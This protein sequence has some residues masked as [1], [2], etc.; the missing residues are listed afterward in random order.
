MNQ[1]WLKPALLGIDRPQVIAVG[2]ALDALLQ[3]VADADEPALAYSRQV[4]VLAACDRAAVRTAAAVSVPPPVADD[5]LQLAADHPWGALLATVFQPGQFS[6][7]GKRL[8]LQACAQLA[9]HGRHLPVA[10]LPQALEAGARL[11]VL[12]EALRAVLGVRGYWLAA[13]NPEW[14]YAS[15]PL[16][17]QASAEEVEQVW[18][19]G[20]SEARLAVFQQQRLEDAAAAR[21]R[22]QDSLKELPARERA[23]FVAALQP[24]LGADDAPLL[25]ALLKDRSREVRAL[26]GPMLARLPDSAHAAYL[27]A[28]MAALLQQ[29]RSGL[30]RRLAWTLEAPATLDPGWAEAAIDGKRPNGEVLGERAWWLYQLAR[31]LPLAWWCRTLEKPAAEVVAW[32]RASDW[33]QALLRAWLERVDASEP[34]WVEALVA[35]KETHARKSELLALLPAAQRERYWPAK[36]QDLIA[37]GLLDDVL[38]STGAAQSLSAAYSQALAPSVGAL[39]GDERLRYDYLLRDRLLELLAVLHPSTLAGVQIAE[40]PATATDAML[41]C[42]QQA[43]ALLALRQALYSPF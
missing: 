32:A 27:Q 36:L 4:G 21:T 15:A 30:L 42:A 41:H 12:R 10:V 20:S 38:D 31:Q 28:Q 35:L 22:L 29:S 5:P 18:N 43:R 1:A 16:E 19:E 39:F 23:A 34:E 26:A 2:G 9:A 11:A 40:P 3:A 33:Y 13:C 6:P 7:W 24:G 14:R 37:Q 8:R 25:Q 17:A